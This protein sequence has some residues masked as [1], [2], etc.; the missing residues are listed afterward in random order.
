MQTQKF[1]D[2]KPVRTIAGDGGDGCISFLQLWANENAGPD[3]GDGGNGG[4]VVFEA[5]TNVSNLSH[6]ETILKADSGEKGRGKDCHGRNAP[7]TVA[8]V[9]VGTIIKNS[10]G[11]VGC[12]CCLSFIFLRINC[13]T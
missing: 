4:H 9:P 1:I 10:N 6:L 2:T 8:K 3:G 7:H 5:C 13:H 11:D 12:I